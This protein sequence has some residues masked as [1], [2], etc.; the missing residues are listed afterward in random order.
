MLPTTIMIIPISSDIGYLYLAEDLVV[1]TDELKVNDGL[2]LDFGGYKRLIGIEF[3][4]DESECIKH[5]NNK[6][7]VFQLVEKDGVKCYSF[8]VTDDTPKSSYQLNKGITFYFSNKGY[9]GF[10]GLDI[11]NI[12]DYRT[13]FLISKL[14]VS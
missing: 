7:Q 13:E 11:F 14:N 12:D 3:F 2:N 5:W 10:L 9:K 8:R 1:F 6:N 4:G